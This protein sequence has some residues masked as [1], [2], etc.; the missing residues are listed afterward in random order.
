MAFPPLSY[1]HKAGEIM[2][3]IEFYDLWF[4][5]ML[6]VALGLLLFGIHRVSLIL[7][8]RRS[9]A[10]VPAGW[11]GPLPSV[12]IQ[13][14]VYNERFVIERLIR[15]VGAIRYP[16]EL[17]HIQVLD[18]STDDTGEQARAAIQT[19]REKGVDITYHHRTE[20]TGYKA[21]ALQAG[22]ESAT[23]EFIAVFDAD[24]IPDED[25]LERMIP[26]FTDPQVGVV[27]AR[28]TYLNREDNFLT[29]LQAILLDGHFLIEQA[30]R[31]AAGLFCNFN[32]TAGMW[33]RRCIDDAGGWRADT[34]TEDLDLSYRAQRR[35]WTLVYRGD[36]TV[37]SELPADMP[38]F[39]SQQYRWAKGAIETSLLQLP[40][41]VSSTLPSRVK[42]EAVMHLLS[43]SSYLL[44]M[45][46]A[47]LLLPAMPEYPD[48]SL[49]Q[50][51][52]GWI[53]IVASVCHFGYF[54]VVLRVSGYS[55]WKGLLYIPGLIV[56]GVSLAINNTRAVVEA[57]L[58]RRSPFVRTPKTGGSATGV[59]RYS[60]GED[61]VFWL[62]CFFFAFY[63]ALMLR[64]AWTSDWASVP[65]FIL[66][67]T[68]FGYAAY[69]GLRTKEDAGPQLSETAI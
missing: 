69:Y 54:I 7:H 48:G 16:R 57:L 42:S 11:P 2:T 26:S 53:L 40:A 56:V 22:L 23:G 27:Q 67:M 19:L 1:Y 28:W 8:L 6:P 34:L 58:H 60:A 20:R 17:L 15:A 45:L 9:A 32:G 68:G 21:G 66:F 63:L 29:R 36:V 13:L 35:G 44:V 43:N 33:R 31:S 49:W 52:L 62:E 25:F 3:S 30:A 14:P 24:F 12:T 64:A 46:L 51:S 55:P 65:I 4:L 18:D 38:A 47:L 61:R 5:A 37:P 10:P 41:L 39:K 59:R 50:A